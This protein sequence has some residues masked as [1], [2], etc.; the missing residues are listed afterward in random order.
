MEVVQVCKSEFLFH[1]LVW[2]R[3]I[4]KASSWGRHRKVSVNE[5]QDI[6]E[7]ITPRKE[8]NTHE[9][10]D[11]CSQKKKKKKEN[12]LSVDAFSPTISQKE[13]TLEKQIQNDF[14]TEIPQS[15]LYNW[16]FH[17][18]HLL[19]YIFHLTLKSQVQI[20][21]E[22]SNRCSCRVRGRKI[23]LKEYS[24]GQTCLSNAIM[25]KA[26][27]LN[28]NSIRLYEDIQE[29]CISGYIYTT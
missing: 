23:C 8:I 11:N 19:F 28:S 16:D 24:I 17:Y 2:M 6:T 21:I 27:K 3:G 1:R 7:K 26:S 5:L 9:T 13:A 20:F 25:K 22:N 10:D 18:I 15:T 29:R 12:P 4:P 14:E